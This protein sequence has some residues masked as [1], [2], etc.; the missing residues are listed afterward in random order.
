[1]TNADEI[2]EQTRDQQRETWER[3]SDGW[4][5]WDDLVLRMLE[6][7]GDEMIRTLA[8]RDDGRHLEVA[9]GTGE[10]GLSIAALVPRGHVVLTDLSAGM[11]DVAGANARARGLRNVEVR[12]CGVDDLPF[13]DA[14]FDTI[15]CRFGFMFF[16]DIPRSVERL[17]RLLRPGGRI[18]AAVWAEPAGNP[19]ATLPMAAIAAEVVLPEPRPD[20]PSLFRCSAPGAIGRMF[21]A[22]GL[23]DVTE[24]DVH[25]TLDPDTARD[26]WDFITEV[27]APV[28]AGLGLADH[29]ARARIRTKVLEQVRS[30]EVEGK[31][32]I[33]IHARCIVGTK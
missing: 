6:P 29:A 21:R 1:M 7:A 9:A 11:L 28:V 26:Y 16:P 33:P 13:A 10:P 20:A 22:V 17:A 30:F 5:K 3:F 31:P 12:A 23:H 27:T 15:S 8:L 24:T 14:S 4:A 2:R 18:A 19:W 32:S 25:S